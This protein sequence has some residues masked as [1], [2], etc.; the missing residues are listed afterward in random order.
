V[1]S[2]KLTTVTKW[3]AKLTQMQSRIFPRRY[4][5]K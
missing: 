1:Y 3:G 4:L 5:G 2:S